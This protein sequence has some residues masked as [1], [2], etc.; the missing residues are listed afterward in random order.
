MLKITPPPVS[1]ILLIPLFLLSGCFSGLNPVSV[2]KGVTSSP[3]PDSVGQFGL[4]EYLYPIN[5]RFEE[6]QAKFDALYTDEGWAQLV[7]DDPE[8]FKGKRPIVKGRSGAIYTCYSEAGTVSTD[9]CDVGKEAD[10]EKKTLQIVSIAPLIELP[11]GVVPYAVRKTMLEIITIDRNQ[12][13]LLKRSYLFGD[14]KFDLIYMTKLGLAIKQ[15]KANPYNLEVVKTLPTAVKFVAG[16]LKLLANLGE[17]ATV[18][19]GQVTEAL[20]TPDPTV[21][22]TG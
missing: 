5:K 19:L 18:Y 17:G 13:R 3:Q 11:N 6:V 21:L 8:T 15:A 22:K 10:S 14:P 7:Q 1:L 2:I 16:F 9:S 20:K 12:E 4:K